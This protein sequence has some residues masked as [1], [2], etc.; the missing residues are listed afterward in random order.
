MKQRFLLFILFIIPFAVNSQSSGI[1][2]GTVKDKNT[3]ET[4]I[5]T[6]V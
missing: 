3:S 4:L 2:Q 1:I 5:G 6:I